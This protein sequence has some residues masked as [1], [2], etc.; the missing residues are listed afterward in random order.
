MIE[1]EADRRC[2]QAVTA[3]FQRIQKVIKA[4]N[5]GGTHGKETQ[6][7]V[8]ETLCQ[9]GCALTYLADDGQ[10][11]CVACDPSWHWSMPVGR[12][13]ASIARALPSYERIFDEVVDAYI[14]GDNQGQS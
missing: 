1:L 2:E 11:R 13:I 5:I 8:G 12:A 4:G 14:G 3:A 7:A 9:C 6:L 10:F